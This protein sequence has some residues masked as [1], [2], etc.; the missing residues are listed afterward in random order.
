[1]DSNSP[2]KKKFRIGDVIRKLSDEH[3]SVPPI[4]PEAPRR[5]L[6]DAAAEEIYE[7]ADASAQNPDTLPRQPTWKGRDFSSGIEPKSRAMPPPMKPEKPTVAPT[8]GV[9]PMSAAMESRELRQTAPHP[10]PVANEPPPASSVVQPVASPVPG[11]DDDDAEQQ[12]DIFKYLSIIYRRKTVV[13]VA[14]VIAAIFSIFRFVTSE[15]FYQAKARLLFAPSQQKVINDQDPYAYYGS[16][17]KLSTHLELLKSTMVVTLASQNLQKRIGPGEIRSGLSVRTGENSG[18]KTDIIELGFTHQDPEIARDALNEV[19]KTYIQYMKSVN[20]QDVTEL[21]SKFET[22]IAKLQADLN[23]KEESLRAFKEKNQMVE[24]ST[25]TNATIA[26]LASLEAELQQVNLDLSSSRDKYN[27][28]RSQISQQELEV[29]QSMTYDNPI[30]AMINS[31]ELQLKSLA[32]EYSPEHYKVKMLKEQIDELKKSASKES[33]KSANSKTLVK[34]PIRQSLLSDIVGMNISKVTLESRRTA[35]E[36]T[37]EKINAQILKLPGMELTYAKLTRETESLI[38]ILSMLRRNYEETKVRRDSQES[39]IKILELATAS[40]GP[41]S[42]KTMKDVMVGI[43]IGLLIGIGLAFLLEYLDQSIKDPLDIQRVLELPLLGVVPMIDAEK[44]LIEQSAD[45]NKTALEPFRALR[46]NIKHLAT[47]AKM[48]TFIICSAVKGEGKTTLA[49]NLSITFAMDGRTVILVDGDL[50]R[51]QMHTIFGIPKELGLSDF[52]LGK[53]ELDQ[54]IKRTRFPNLFIITSGERPDNPAELVGN[55]RYAL[56]IAQLRERAD[57]VI[58]DSPALLP[59]SDTITMAPH[60]DAGFMVVRALWTPARAALQAKNQLK[61]VGVNLLGCIL[62][63]VPHSRGYYPYYYG[64]YRYYAYKYTYEEDQP[65][66]PFSMREIGL[67]IESKFKEVF[68]SVR[69]SV[70]RII[71]IAGLLLR[72]LGRRILLWVLALALVVLTGAIFWLRGPQS[73]GK[74]KAYEI[75]YLGTT[76]TGIAGGAIR[77]SGRSVQ[78]IPLEAAAV[79]PNSLLSYV[80]PFETIAQVRQWFEAATR[81][82]APTWLKWYDS[83]GFRYPGGGRAEW[84]ESGRYDRLIRPAADTLAAWSLD[85]VWDE[86]IQS[87][88]R[89][90]GALI[91]G[92]SAKETVG[93]RYVIIWQPTAD[94]KWRIIGQKQTQVR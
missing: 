21:L 18:E 78:G 49:A 80:T 72:S 79:A 74:K 53:S 62:N 39:D 70:P 60:V 32:A 45:Q 37:I 6:P 12:I 30:Q 48:K 19:C 77:Q 1:M 11:I 87:P 36:Q 73:G 2:E 8:D 89:K 59:V 50:R 25:E 5:P 40:S 91:S 63:G 7:H 85:S 9:G 13:L 58:V 82:T 22:Q 17:H 33:A 90:T 88:F 14:I 34:N 15:K 56:L 71:P 35:L 84:N 16:E 55:A 10:V 83:T 81:F 64:Y 94:G 4:P 47:T 31:L 61:R 68:Q 44:P 42:T 66:S 93:I 86:D 57:I 23:T 65:E 43:M 28:V 92:T 27:A 52:L 38:G 41:I 75:E 76:G 67:K 24:L 26:Q 54:I 20:N 69:F 46:A 29:V 3:H 51:S